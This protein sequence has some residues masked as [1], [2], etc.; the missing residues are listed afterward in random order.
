MRHDERAMDSDRA[1]S[2]QASFAKALLDPERQVPDGITSHTHP[3]P[4]KR[5][6][7]YR[8]NV[9]V[10]L[11]DALAARFP[12]VQRIVGEEFFRAMAGV[13]A[14]AHPPR[15]PL[16]MTYGEGFPAF[17]ETFAPAAELPYL[18]DVARLEAART[19]AFHAADAT[20]LPARAFSALGPTDLETLRIRF[21]PGTAI[22]RS[23]H[24]VVTIWAMNADE[25]EPAPIE[26]WRGEDALISREGFDVV[27]RRLPPGGAVFLSHLL[28]DATLADAASAAMQDSAA[29]DLAEN[30]A[31]L[32]SAHLVT[33]LMTASSP[34]P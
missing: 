18:A 11:I 10:S 14:P 22:V 21:A 13:F 9:V 16:I 26:D 8:N 24:P 27:V 31:G 4:A 34:A 29:F 12:A 17:I 20:A 3:A 19:H 15:S 5:F 1:S 2:D 6:A 28:A 7:V 33:E 25:A 30:I 32:I 23:S